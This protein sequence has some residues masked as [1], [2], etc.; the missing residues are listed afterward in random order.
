MAILDPGDEVILFAPYWVSYPEMVKIA[1]GRPKILMP[2]EERFVPDLDDIHSSISSQTKAIILNSPNNPSGAI[3]PQEIVNALVCLCEQNGIYLLMDDIYHQLVF[4]DTPWT[5]GYQFTNQS[6]DSS[7]L[8]VINGIS[9]TY[10]MTGFRIGWAIAAKS[11]IS[12]MGNIQSQTTSGVSTLLQSGALGALTGSQDVV[13]ELCQSIKINRDVTLAGLMSIPGIR[14]IE[15]QGTFY[16]LPDFSTYDPNSV[17]LSKR[18]LEEAYVAV[19]PGSA[20]GM[21]GHLRL[22]YSGDKNE[23]EEAIERI[24]RLLV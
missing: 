22:S 21:E 18:I 4:G 6:I 1:G 5:P 7:Y 12:V 24:K 14:V 20:F 17:A 19:V 16:C 8:V 11:V 10:G 9:K 13:D 23:I 15:P 2:R 3:Y